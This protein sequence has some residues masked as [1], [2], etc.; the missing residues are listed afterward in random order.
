M[1]NNTK[2]G[3][4]KD[5]EELINRWDEVGV[6]DALMEVAGCLNCRDEKIHAGKFMNLYFLYM[7]KLQK[8]FFTAIFFLY[9]KG[10]CML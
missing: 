9:S 6:P 5:V 8:L 1:L 3:F 7:N 2:F 4:A 10:F